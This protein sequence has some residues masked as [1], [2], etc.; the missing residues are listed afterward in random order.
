[1]PKETLNLLLNAEATA[2]LLRRVLDHLLHSGGSDE[3]Q[4][5][6]RAVMDKAA[7]AVGSELRLVYHQ[8]RSGDVV[9]LIRA[10]GGLSVAEISERLT[11]L[12]PQTYELHLEGEFVVLGEVETPGDF[13]VSEPAVAA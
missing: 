5:E 6:V 11:E 7:D 2:P 3:L 9:T 13:R 10:E 1:M 8:Y 4:A 12:S